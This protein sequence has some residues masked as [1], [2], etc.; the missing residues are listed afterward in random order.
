M[1]QIPTIELK[2]QPQPKQ[3]EFHLCPANEV[4][5][6]GAAGGGKSEA[7][8]NDAVNY[9]LRYPGATI[10]LFR[11]TFPELERTLIKKFQEVV[12]ESMASYNST[13]HVA[14]F[15]P[16]TPTST[17][18][19]FG[20]CKE[21]NDVYQYQSVEFD[22]LGFDELTHFTE[23]QYTYLLSR[24]RSVKG[25]PKRVRCG[26]NPG[27]IGHAW[28]K[29]R[30]RVS[31][32]SL[33]NKVWTDEVSG[34]S[35]CFIPAKL[36]DNPALLKAD[37]HYEQQLNVLSETERR[38]LKDGD[39]DV[40]AGQ[41]F[42]EWRYDRHVVEPFELPSF[43]SRILGF[44]Y[45]YANPSAGEWLTSDY[46][47][48][49]WVYKE[50][51]E[52]KL[53]EKELGEKLRMLNGDAK[54]TPLADPSIFAKKK[55]EF[56]NEVSIADEISRHSGFYFQPAN[57]NRISGWAR[58][59]EY[60]KEGPACQIHRA[61]GWKTCPKLHVFS[62]C[63]HLIRTLPQLIHD[64]R[65]VE[66]VDTTG[67]DHAADALRYGLSALQKGDPRQDEQV[68]RLIQQRQNEDY[69]GQYTGLDD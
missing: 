51:Y 59:R 65:V 13:K 5:Y 28:V 54:L 30:F 2:Y 50:L 32:A 33:R 69:Y 23:Y 45:G 24:L 22:Y 63:T 40:F 64:D 36:A 15:Y 18:L 16:F 9:A 7:L 12:P 39:W 52:A 41:Y 19:Y 11:R 25:F 29:D 66:D 53:S 43:F 68:R 27:N 35:R 4:L 8:L 20:S 62:N 42:P 48:R 38:A 67:E 21:E 37:P 61:M 46:D 47:S 57:N 3:L 49:V 56:G 26:T 1:S 10:G 58:L 60:L 31:D 55:N 34:L 14:V 6:G 44:D 17:H